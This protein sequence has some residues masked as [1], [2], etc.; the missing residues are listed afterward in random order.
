MLK[1]FNDANRQT[2]LNPNHGQN[3]NQN[4]NEGNTPLK[5]NE[6]RNFSFF[7]LFLTIKYRLR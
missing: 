7:I 6:Y 4:T 2:G 5:P 3:P 1:Q